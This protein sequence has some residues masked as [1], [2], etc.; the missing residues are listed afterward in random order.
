MPR[1]GAPTPPTSGASRPRHRPP[2]AWLERHGIAFH[3]PVYYLSAS[4]A[5]HPARRRRRRH[6][7]QAG[8]RRECRRRRDSL[9]GARRAAAARLA[10]APSRASRCAPATGA[11]ETYRGPRRGAGVRWICRQRRDAGAAPRRRGGEPEAH[12]ARHALQHRRRHP[13]GA[14]GRRPGQRRLARHARGACRS[15]KPRLGPRGARLS[16]RHRRRPYGPPV[17][18]RRRRPRARDVGDA[19]PRHSLRETPG[20]IAYAILDAKLHE[21]AGYERAIRSEVPPYRSGIDRRAGALLGIPGGALQETIA[22]YNAAAVGDPAR[23]DATRLDGLAAAPGLSPPKSNWCRPL[24]RPPYLAYPLV[25]AIAYTFG[26]ARHQRRR[27]GDG[28]LRPHAGPVRRR[29]DHRPLPRHRAQCGRHA[30]RP[31]VRPHRRSP[32]RRVLPANS[33][34]S[35]LQ[36]TAEVSAVGSKST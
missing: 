22:R 4:S 18:R 7:A 23:F 24:D 12:L 6:P 17:H 14:G 11:R 30:A 8:E 35:S 15:E 5:A 2:I 34:Q 13:H 1:A 26:G 3:Q 21:I 29:R 16:L 31:R 10:T 20:R 32:G 25:G 33:E 36:L 27:R 9:R 19:R 28:E